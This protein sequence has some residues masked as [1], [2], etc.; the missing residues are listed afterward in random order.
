MCASPLLRSEFINPGP[1]TNKLA[2]PVGE[3]PNES[4]L[5]YINYRQVNNV[6]ERPEGKQA[7]PEKMIQRL[8]S[9]DYKQTGRHARHSVQ[10]TVI[11]DKVTFTIS[12]CLAIIELQTGGILKVTQSSPSF[13]ASVAEA[14]ESGMQEEGRK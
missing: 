13:T 12:S 14:Q 6:N 7:G 10:Q 3:K 4:N 5:I 8:K 11:S 1:Q 9:N 2:P